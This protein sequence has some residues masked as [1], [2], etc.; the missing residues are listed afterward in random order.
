MPCN[1]MPNLEIFADVIY[2]RSLERLPV[3]PIAG[4]DLELA[5]LQG[6]LLPGE[7]GDCLHYENETN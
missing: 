6:T 1:S 7:V 3:R 5:P 4:H 2:G